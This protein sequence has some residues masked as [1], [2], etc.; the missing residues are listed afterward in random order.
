MSEFAQITE[1]GL[2]VAALVYF[3]TVMFERF[4]RSCSVLAGVILIG[5]AGRTLLPKEATAAFDLLATV[6]ISGLL[7]ARSYLIWKEWKDKS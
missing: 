7:L 6:G 1:I 4:S 2:L 3:W 5:V